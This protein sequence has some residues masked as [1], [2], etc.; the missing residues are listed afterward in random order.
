[1]GGS[2]SLVD[3]L[4][5][6]DLAHSFQLYCMIPLSYVILKATSPHSQNGVLLLHIDD[7]LLYGLGRSLQ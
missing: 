1:M 3:L 7:L 2:S 6:K 4:Q 5:T